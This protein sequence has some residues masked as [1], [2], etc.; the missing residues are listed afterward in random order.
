VPFA[1]VLGTLPIKIRK[2]TANE[3]VAALRTLQV[4]V[5]ATKSRTPLSLEILIAG[6]ALVALLVAQ[7]MLSAAIQ[8]TNYYG[9]DGKMAQATILTVFEFGSRFE[10]NN[11]NPI[12]GVGSQLLPM[13]VWA[14]PAYW[15]FGLVDKELATD[16]SAVVALA[17]FGAAVYVMARCFDVTILASLVAAQSSI[18][19]FAPAVLILQL[20]TVFCLTPGN[21]V[22]YAPHMVALGLLGRLEPGSWRSFGLITAGIF[23]LLFYSLCCDPLWTMVSG[24]SWSVA[25]VVVTFGPLRMKTI[26]VRCA[27]LGLSIALLVASG[28]AQYLY[29]LSQYTAR[30]Q[31]PEVLDR[32]RG[33][34]L[35]S[36][37]FYSPNMKYYYLACALGWLLGLLALRGRSRLFVAAGAVSCAA[38]F[39]YSVLYLLLLNGTWVLPI[40]TYVEQCLFLLL[41]T[42][43]VAG[44]WGALSVTASA[45]AGIITRAVSRVS[46][47]QAV[48]QRARASARMLV[49]RMRVAAIRHHVPRLA[50]LT[51]P[52]SRPLGGAEP[53]VQSE[54]MR[55]HGRYIASVS[56]ARAVAI[57]LHF[58][59][60]AV[61]PGYVVNFAL[62][63]AQ[64]LAHMYHERWPNEAALV[65]FLMDN[66]RQSAGEPFRGSVMFWQ[67][68]YPAL[69]TIAN[70]WAR[71][72]PTANEYSQL[73]TPQALYFVHVLLKKD[74]RAN[75]NW[76]QPFFVD[77][78]YTEAYWN[79]L[80]MFGVRYFIGYARL[81]LAEDLEFPV[82][83]L[84]HARLAEEPT[85]WNIYELPHPNVGNYSPTETVMAGSGAE[86]MRIFGKRTFDP[87]QQAVLSTPIAE[88]LV[89]AREMRMSRIRGGLHVSGRSD[90]TSLV[91]LPQQFSNCLRARDERVRLVRANLMMTGLIFSGDLDTDIVFDYGI[92]TPACRRA[93]LADMKRLNL[94]IN[95]RMAH[96]SGDRL[97]P[98][99]EDATAKLRA[100]VGA[101][102]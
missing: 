100:I 21:A 48:G 99:W 58:A 25:F 93:D 11:I 46:S 29:T 76:F 34:G 3:T 18:V 4:T 51:L 6:F 56:H 79:A 62:N 30:V 12:E 7:W 71:A 75:L 28:V 57:A 40:P 50:Y 15:P 14:N 72:I 8:G 39:A 63:R 26:L 24:I 94:K 102:K 36:A 2:A 13:N 55:L 16:L 53:L 70:G 91:V 5:R 95:L 64:T 90:G 92:F 101:I 43:A 83:T 80:R 87:T 78:T 37:L 69:L 84:P 97:F 45:S 27:T 32:E 49:Q 59:A 74:V 61:I 67:P 96:L 31:F 85:A 47:S 77:G 98:D 20:P 33:S 81:P 35:A 73:V 66:V 82:T 9:V 41:V 44:Y 68:D 65:G 17:I 54:P 52:V 22:V 38:Y 1:V 42:T 19:L 10:I 88:R 60:A 86:I 89:P 23:G